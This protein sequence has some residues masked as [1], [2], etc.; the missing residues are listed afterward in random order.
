MGMAYSSHKTSYVWLLTSHGVQGFEL[1][2]LNYYIDFYNKSA[3]RNYINFWEWMNTCY[4]FDV[5]GFSY[6]WND[7]N[8][9][10]SNIH[11]I[12]SKLKGE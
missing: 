3:D 7:G 9:L 10:M 1:D 4:G 6:L 11:P 5:H 8:P 2:D 12:N